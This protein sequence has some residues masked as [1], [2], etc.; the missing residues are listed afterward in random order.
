MD[1]RPRIELRQE[2]S[3]RQ[4]HQIGLEQL[5]PEYKTKELRDALDLMRRLSKY[6]LDDLVIEDQELAKAM[7]DSH[8]TFIRSRDCYYLSKED[9]LDHFNYNHLQYVA[10]GIGENVLSVKFA[11]QFQKND[12]EELLEG[13]VELKRTAKRSYITA[14]DGTKL[15]EAR[16]AMLKLLANPGD[17]HYDLALDSI[18]DLTTKIHS[19]NRLMAVPTI[20]MNQYLLGFFLRI[21]DYLTMQNYVKDTLNNFILCLGKNIQTIIVDGQNVPTADFCKATARNEKCYAV[22]KKFIK[23][24]A[25]YFY[26]DENSNISVRFTPDLDHARIMRSIMKPVQ[27]SID[28]GAWV[29]PEELDYEKLELRKAE[30]RAKVKTLPGTKLLR[31]TKFV[32]AD[33]EYIR[34]RPEDAIRRKG[35]A[36]PL[37]LLR[38]QSLTIPHG[39]DAVD[40]ELAFEIANSIYAQ[41]LF[42]TPFVELERRKSALHNDE[43]EIIKEIHQRAKPYVER[44]GGTYSDYAK[45]LAQRDMLTETMNALKEIPEDASAEKIPLLEAV[46]K[47]KANLVDALR[48]TKQGMIKTDEAGNVYVQD[49]EKFMEAKK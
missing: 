19:E 1:L 4:I 18:A 15:I 6:S 38:N 31:N 3:Q 17:M 20:S 21:P 42:Q 26:A 12:L 46:K 27:V 14:K 40:Q 35:T 29:N 36:Q 7:L 2:A 24:H 28:N 32:S 9:L 5:P 33:L 22:D 30:G 23:R 34:G 43:R 8:I 39:L 47:Y 45:I 44:V 13:P 25:Q 37:V 49:F 48:A 16:G 41:L 11:T 10:I